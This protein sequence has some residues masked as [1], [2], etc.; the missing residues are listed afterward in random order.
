M[1][2]RDVDPNEAK[3]KVSLIRFVYSKELCLEY[4]KIDRYKVRISMISL[5]VLL[6]AYKYAAS[7]DMKAKFI[8][9]VI[10]VWIAYCS[11]IEQYKCK[12]Y[13]EAVKFIVG[14]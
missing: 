3:H 9:G 5:A 7:Q 4:F 12:C 13:S 8:I 11:N 6:L 2:D 14:E 10:G 1:T